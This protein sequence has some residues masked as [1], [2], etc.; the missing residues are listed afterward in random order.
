M[1]NLN[2]IKHSVQRVLKGCS[3]GS[4]IITQRS[5]LD[6]NVFGPFDQ[7]LH[8]RQWYLRNG[9]KIS[10]VNYNIVLNARHVMS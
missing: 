4:N 10:T 1:F 5:I 6:Q 9:C 7:G 2:Q 3:N 8:V